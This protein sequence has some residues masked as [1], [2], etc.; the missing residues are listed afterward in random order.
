M[1]ATSR[2]HA[3]AVIGFLLVG[4]SATSVGAQ[5]ASRLAV[6]PAARPAGFAAGSIQGTI[7]DEHG[8]ALAGAVV[9]VLGATT[10]V[11]VSDKSGRFDFGTLSPGPYLL[12]VHL[13]GFV[14]PKART[15]QVGAGARTIADMALR[16]AGSPVLAA[17]FGPSETDRV[18]SDTPDLKDADVTPAPSDS[19]TVWRIR[20]ARRSVLKE[21]T[22]PSEW[23]IDLDAPDEPATFGG[24]IAG[25]VLARAMES[26]R[27][28]TSFF[29]A[30]PF[31]G[32]VN[33]LTSGSFDS[34]EGLLSSDSV[35]RNV[36][37]VSVGAPVGDWADWAVRGAVTQADISSW[38]I[39]G[40][41]ATRAPARHRREIGLSY[42]TQRYDGGNPLALRDIA[43]GSRNAGSVYAY[44][45]MS[46]A[47]GL[48]ISYGAA[49]ARYDY[50]QDRSLFS[51]RVEVTVSPVAH[52]RVNASVSRR[53]LAPGAEEF[54]PPSD[55]G[56][57]LP[58]QRT[59][60]SIDGE[61]SF[62]AE[63][64]THAEA[65][66]ERDFGASTIALRAFTQ[67]VDGQLATVFGGE[68]PDRPAA[69][70]GHYM[71]GSA[72]DASAQ[73]CSIGFKT[74]L[75]SRIRGTFEYTLASAALVGDEGRSYLMLLAP[76]S[77]RPTR[78]RL[79]DI[80]TS[81]E[82]DLPETAT[83]LVVLYRFSNGFARPGRAGDGS[84]PAVDGRFDVQVRQQLPFMNFSNARW[85]M[86]LAVRNFFRDAAAEQSLYDELL[87]VQPPKRVVGGVTLRF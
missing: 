80:S 61:R 57:W 16:R 38:T 18:P 19:E 6:P 5:V 66:I 27:A 73:G 59:F 44:D 40:S 24:W 84:G 17:G 41:Y 56:L 76:S 9:S 63:K 36:A 53:A 79:H 51:P 83:R 25:D 4:G 45:S 69:K 46:L 8:E 67:R 54:L 2:L 60:S 86:L 15:V 72:G 85:E 10:T 21:A 39:A 28:A 68:L 50:L 55:S 52:L 32:Q 35:A 82:A 47:P 58:P 64:T 3:S 34:P 14:A 26:A 12:R 48:T 11:A 43:E 33:L 23:L 78:E 20:H 13:A 30:T 71:V 87:V 31:S 49:F 42:A 70:L 77:I 29:A 74:L 22:I 7:L 75:A 81:I 37:N 65:S 62:T 1:A